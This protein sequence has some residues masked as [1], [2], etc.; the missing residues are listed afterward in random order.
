M[1]PE[2]GLEPAHP[3][4]R[5]ILNPLRLPISPLWHIY[6]LLCVSRFEARL[7]IWQAGVFYPNVTGRVRLLFK[8]TLINSEFPQHKAVLP[9]SMAV[10]PLNMKKKV[11]S[12]F[13]FFVL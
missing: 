3:R 1:V 9:Y 12:H 8:E 6:R 7:G 2:A 4:G 10:K 5:G 11:K 13:T